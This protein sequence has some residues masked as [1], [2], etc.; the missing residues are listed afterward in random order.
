MACCMCYLQHTDA[1]P[2]QM[3]HWINPCCRHAR[4]LLMLRPCVQITCGGVGRQAGRATPT[5]TPR[6]ACPATTQT[7]TT[8]PK[9]PSGGSFHTLWLC[10]G[11][12]AS[13]REP[14]RC[15]PYPHVPSKA[16]FRRARAKLMLQLSGLHCMHY[17]LVDEQ[18]RG[19]RYMEG[20]AG[21][22]WGCRGG[23]I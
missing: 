7:P 8:P 17:T 6:A 10:A 20:R 3:M 23:G 16:P 1:T 5:G 14:L 15:L 11:C 18:G 2:H 4:V 9:R 21:G 19:P 22:G 13:N 12:N